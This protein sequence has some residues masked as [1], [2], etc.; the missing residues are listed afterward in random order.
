MP[1]HDIPA[2]NAPA[3]LAGSR[4]FVPIAA[5]AGILLAATLLLWANYGGA[6][7]YEM[8]VAGIALCF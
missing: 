4:L 6:V 3:C 1:G 2:G 8:I 7:F 5:V